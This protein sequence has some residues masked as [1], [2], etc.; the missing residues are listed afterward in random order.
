MK[1]VYLGLGSNLGE[2]KGYI[3]GAL[4]GLARAGVAIDG[5]SSLYETEPVGYTDQPPFYNA[6]ARGLTGL[7]PRQLLNAVLAIEKEL[8]RRRDI[9][10]GPRTID[11]DILL[12]G[13]EVFQEEDLLIPHPRLAERAFV[14]IPL[15][16]LAPSLS[17]PDG[18]KIAD[19]AKAVDS[20]GVKR[21]GNLGWLP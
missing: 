14:L 20:R 12:Y 10:W 16:E 5:V 15:L 13:Q 3:K 7:Q 4:A 18:R 19:L 9:R 17:L 11:I 21:I 8:G 1:E 2:R 6:V